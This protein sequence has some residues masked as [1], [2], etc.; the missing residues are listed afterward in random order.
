MDSIDK[1]SEDSLKRV[2][3]VA[4]VAVLTLANATVETAF[5]LA[6][7]TASKGVV[8]IENVFQEAVE[9]LF[10]KREDLKLRENPA[11]LAEELARTALHYKN[12]I[13]HAMWREQQATKSVKKLGENMELNNFIDKLCENIVN[14]A[15]QKIARLEEIL[16]FIAKT[17]AITIPTEVEETKAERELKKLVPKRLFKGTLNLEILKMALGE[18]EYEWYIEID[19]KDSE[20]GKKVE[21][22]VNFMDEKR[23]AYEILKAVSA[24]YNQTNPEHLLKFLKDLE[25]INLLSFK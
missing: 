20:F 21:E 2:G 9:E 1:V 4:T 3:W 25:K 7:K 15:K 6:N 13:E 14:Q 16:S 23:N 12:K 22:F 10:N 5:Q 8:K 11:E 19:E 24:E 18:K 17:L